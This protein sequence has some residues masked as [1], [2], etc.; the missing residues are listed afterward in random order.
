MQ[1]HVGFTQMSSKYYLTLT[2][3]GGSLKPTENCFCANC[4][5]LV[6]D[7][8]QGMLSTRAK[9]GLPSAHTCYYMGASSEAVA[10]RLSSSLNCQCLGGQASNSKATLTIFFLYVNNYSTISTLET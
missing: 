5:V 2:W 7:S 9:L 3:N 8:E 4:V 6:N 1:S 10:R